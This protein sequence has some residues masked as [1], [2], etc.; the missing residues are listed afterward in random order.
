[1]GY[2]LWIVRAAAITEYRQPLVVD[3]FD[4]PETPERGVVLQVEASGICQS[5]WHSWM[6]HE[7]LPGLPHVPGHE[8]VGVVVSVGPLVSDWEIGD[9][10]TVPF[11]VGCGDCRSCRDGYLNT[12]DRAFTPGFSVWGS[13]AEYV[14]IDHADLNLVRL[15]DG[16]DSVDAVA[17]G[18]RF[19][20]AFRAVADRG[21]VRERDWLVVHGCGGVGLSAVMIGSAF[22]ARVVA[23]DIDPASLA[24]ASTLGAEVVVD[25]RGHGFLEHILDVTSGGAQVSIEAVGRTQTVRNSL[26]SLRKHGRHVQVGLLLA[27]HGEPAIPME[28]VIMGEQEILGVRGMPATDYGRVFELVDSGAVDPSRLV[29]GTVSLDDASN[30]VEVMGDFTGV[31]VTVIDRF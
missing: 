1:V 2:A 13:W 4:D 11:S 19:I 5:D 21:R 7:D 8:M 27:E 22:G 25:A 15:P 16:L 30:V 6:G 24:L 31:G 3:Q 10:V 23:V 29:T 17:L 26:A 18:C 12:C 20:T 28:P 9:R 14:A